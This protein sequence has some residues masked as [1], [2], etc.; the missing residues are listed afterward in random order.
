MIL[1]VGTIAGTPNIAVYNDLL[2]K[3]F[4]KFDFVACV[5]FPIL[6]LV[7]LYVRSKP[8]TGKA[9]DTDS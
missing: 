9:M 7:W 1:L 2:T 5:L 3:Y 6:L 8:D 4:V